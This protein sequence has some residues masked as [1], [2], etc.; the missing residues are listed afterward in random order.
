M[1]VYTLLY[2]RLAHHP[3]CHYLFLNNIH[4]IIVHD[5]Y[6]GTRAFCIYIPVHWFS[7]SFNEDIIFLNANEI[8]NSL[9][10]LSSA[11]WQEN[12]KKINI[13]CY[14]VILTYFNFT[15]AIIPKI[16]DISKRFVFEK[17]LIL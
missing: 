5:E 13:L 9:L 15:K 8:L 17:K 7:Q 2:Y 4:Y 14:F 12:G 1:T 6:D 3:P 11:V 10:A 16:F